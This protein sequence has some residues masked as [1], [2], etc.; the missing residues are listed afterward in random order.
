GLV[1]RIG[2]GHA[3]G[4]F[5]QPGRR[6]DGVLPLYQG[7]AI[8]VEA[9]TDARDVIADAELP[10]MACAEGDT[11]DGTNVAAHGDGVL[12]TR[13]KRIARLDDDSARLHV[14]AGRN[15]AGRSAQVDR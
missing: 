3:V 13:L 15:R 9:G 8:L 5:G 1:R 12:R 6:Q 10:V 2:V 4:R 7:E 14:D 11:L